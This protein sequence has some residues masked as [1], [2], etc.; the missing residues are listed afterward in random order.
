MA[1]AR[2]FPSA[3]P[4]SREEV[5]LL[6]ETMEQ[7]LKSVDDV[8]QAAREDNPEDIKQTVP[9]ESPNAQVLEEGETNL[10]DIAESP[11]PEVEFDEKMKSVRLKKM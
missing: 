5:L 6:G 3:R 7:M 2:D 8:I 4:G 9:Q 11:K 1:K 10:D